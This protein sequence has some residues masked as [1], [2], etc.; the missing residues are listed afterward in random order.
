MRG[1]QVRGPEGGSQTVWGVPR[2]SHCLCLVAYHLYGEYGAENLL[3]DDWIVW[4]CARHHGWLE[5]S[6]AGLGEHP[7]SPD[8]Q[9]CTVGESPLEM[10]LHSLQ[11]SLVDQWPHLGIGKQRIGGEPLGG[12]LDDP[13]HYPVGNIGMNH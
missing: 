5:I 11:T 8:P 12:C 10:V 3:A 1:A 7:P 2:D 13:L 6:A 9:G 4:S